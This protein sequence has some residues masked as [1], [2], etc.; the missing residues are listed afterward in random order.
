MKAVT[1]LI[2]A[3][4][5]IYICRT[6]MSWTV[7]SVLGATDQQCVFAIQAGKHVL[8]WG[9]PAGEPGARVLRGAVHL[10]GGSRVL[11]EHQEHGRISST[12]LASS[13]WCPPKNP[14]ILFC[15]ST[16]SLLGR[17]PWWDFLHPQI[18]KD[19]LISW[20]LGPGLFPKDGNQCEPNP[21]LH[22]GNCTDKRG[23]F[24]CSCV[25]PYYGKTCEL[26]A[27]RQTTESQSSRPG[28]GIHPENGHSAKILIHVASL[29]AVT[30]LPHLYLLH[31]FQ[32][33]PSVPPM[34]PQPVS[35]FAPPS[36]TLSGASVCQDSNYRATNGAAS[37][38]VWF[39][40][41]QRLIPS[42]QT[43]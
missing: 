6:Q 38:K 7:C 11:R 32:N 4:S 18:Y 19:K 21:C 22:G 28:K 9:D 35:S 5:D 24:N 27:G 37:P 8:D 1:S 40:S 15:C 20:R 29:I 41:I 16:G 10:W 2:R 31:L 17:L 13:L 42:V 25:A 30:S 26:G 14:K 34:V 3:F 36:T 23:A 12:V 39:T 43:S 33:I